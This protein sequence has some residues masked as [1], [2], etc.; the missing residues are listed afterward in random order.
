MAAMRHRTQT[1]LANAND[2]SRCRPFLRDGR[3]WNHRHLSPRQ[4][5]T[6]PLLQVTEV[7]RP[8]LFQRDALYSRKSQLNPKNEVCRTV[9]RG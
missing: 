8:T 4:A 5:I 2:A 9:P 6:R 1:L 3:P 7:A